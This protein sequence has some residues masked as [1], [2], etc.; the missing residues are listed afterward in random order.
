[1]KTCGYGAHPQYETAGLRRLE[2]YVTEGSPRLRHFAEVTAV[3]A[4]REVERRVSIA[5]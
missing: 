5:L 4:K 3:L 1:V 2:R